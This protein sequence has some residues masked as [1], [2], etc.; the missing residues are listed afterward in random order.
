MARLTFCRQCSY[1]KLPAE[2]SYLCFSDNEKLAI[3]T[4]LD[5]RAETN[6]LCSLL[7][8][9]FP[10]LLLSGQISKVFRGKRMCYRSVEAAETMS[11]TPTGS[12]EVTASSRFS[13]QMVKPPLPAAV[14]SR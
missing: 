8:L 3:D 4:R 13:F 6:V 1:A 12:L 10:L 2:I 9:F 5:F 14:G 7:F 11:G